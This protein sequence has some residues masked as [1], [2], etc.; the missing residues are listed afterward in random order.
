MELPVTVSLT[1]NHHLMDN[2]PIADIVHRTINMY[3]PERYIRFF[4]EALHLLKTMRNCIHN[5]GDGQ[6]KEYVE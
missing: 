5:C 2:K 1:I 3:A 6:G 4:A